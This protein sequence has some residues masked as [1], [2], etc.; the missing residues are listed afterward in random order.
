M[1]LAREP[2]IHNSELVMRKGRQ[3]KYHEKEYES[4]F[5]RETNHIFYAALIGKHFFRGVTFSSAKIIKSG[6]TLVTSY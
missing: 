1:F 3:Y 6:L 2:K 4:N 5:A